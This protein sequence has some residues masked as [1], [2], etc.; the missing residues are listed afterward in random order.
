MGMREHLSRGVAPILLRVTLGVIFLWAGSAKLAGRVS[1]SGDDAAR[2]AAIGVPPPADGDRSASQDVRR[3][4]TEITLPILR[5]A[6]PAHGA[7][8]AQRSTWP[9]WAAGTRA[10][11]IAWAAS[12]VDV[13]FGVFVL[14]GMLTRVCA[15]GMAAH[16]AGGLWFTVCTPAI[17]SGTTVLGLWPSHDPWDMAFWFRPI[18]ILGLMALALALACLGPGAMSL[19]RPLLGPPSSRD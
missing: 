1:V 6:D 13:V 8:A 11:S 2:L 14:L 5:A 16:M 12:I 7:D 17:Q 15:L 18:C 4:H 10:A 3:L 9:Q 19:D